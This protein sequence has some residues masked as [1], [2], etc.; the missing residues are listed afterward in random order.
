MKNVVKVFSKSTLILLGLTATTM[1]ID[2]AIHKKMF[3]TTTLIISDQK[4]NDIMKIVKFL[5]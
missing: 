4:K 5:C 2:T 1:G 3:G